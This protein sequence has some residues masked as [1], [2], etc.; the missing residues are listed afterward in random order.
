MPLGG[1]LVT[2]SIL[3]GMICLLLAGWMDASNQKVL[4]ILFLLAALCLIVPSVRNMR[5]HMYLASESHLR[6]GERYQV[7]AVLARKESNFHILCALVSDPRRFAFIETEI[8]NVE[9]GDILVVQS[10]VFGGNFLSPL[11]PEEIQR[12]VAA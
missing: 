9:S 1:R 7:L 11:S 6:R 8:E 4:A 2:I 10:A 5:R 12:E 3:F